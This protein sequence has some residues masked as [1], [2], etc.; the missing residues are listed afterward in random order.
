MKYWFKNAIIY[1]L[2]VDAFQDGNG[3][4]CGDFKGLADRLEYLSAIGIHTVWLL[5]FLEIPFKDNGYDV[6]DYYQIDSRLGNMGNFVDFLDIADE[7]GL[8]VI[9]DLPLN[10]TSEEHPWFQEARRNPDS[11]FR[12]F[13]IWEKEKPANADEHVAFPGEQE[14]NW[15]YDE[16]A[17]AYYYHTFYDFQPDLNYANPRVM[18]E[19]RQIIYFWLRL[20]VSGFRVDALSHMIREKGSVHF[21]EPFLIVRELTRFVEEIR[22][23]GVLLGETDV[24]SAEYQ[25]FFGE[26]ESGFQMLLNFYLSQYMFLAFAKQERAPLD[27]ALNILPKTNSFQQFAN[28]L[29]NHDELNLERLSESERNRVFEKF[30][31]QENMQIFGRGIRRRLAPMFDNDRKQIELA[32]SLLFSLPGSPVVRYGDE[33]GM[34]EDLSQKGRNSVRT[35][36]QW[37][38]EKNGGFSTAN[39]KDLFK[40]LIKKG[41]YSYERVNVEA[42]YRNSDSLLNWM[43]KL[44]RVRTRCL[45]FGRGDFRILDTVHPAVFAH[46][47]KLKDEVAVAV[48]NFSEEEVVVQLKMGVDQLQRLVDVFGDAIYEEQDDENTIKINPLG[49]RWFRARVENEKF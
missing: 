7:H 28:F 2:N 16:E 45:Q 33:I 21:K 29:R 49:Y 26:H 34:G 47:A 39:A 22:T 36:M 31:P 4:G 10:H 42:Q 23:D 44:F 46:Y 17:G 3:D 43:E 5:P 20:G 37:S 13:Y 41:E 15:K 12:D 30:A 14:S 32:N 27:Y 24:L 9:M 35:V 8:R 1:S 40:P 18:Q 19:V 48:H 25:K 38:A 6:S 11:P